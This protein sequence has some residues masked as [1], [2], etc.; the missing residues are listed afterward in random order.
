MMGTIIAWL[1]VIFASAMGVL[2]IIHG[3]RKI[4]KGETSFRGMRLLKHMNEFKGSLNDFSGVEILALGLLL[5]LSALLL[6]YL[7]FWG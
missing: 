3:L 5:M 2:C 7:F 6:F 4:I 1:Y